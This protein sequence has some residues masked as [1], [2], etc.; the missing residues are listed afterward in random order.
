MLGLI[1][2]FQAPQIAITQSAQRLARD[3]SPPRTHVTQPCMS[4]FH[5]ADTVVCRANLQHTSLELP[6]VIGND[7]R[8]VLVCDAL[9]MLTA[10]LRARWSS[11]EIKR[12]LSMRQ[13]RLLRFW[14]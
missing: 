7:F 3:E 2:G 10:T 13:L 6:S 12:T 1:T 4:T 14:R 5:P 8:D 11:L 9:G